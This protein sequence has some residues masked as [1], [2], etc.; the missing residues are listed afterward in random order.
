MYLDV[1]TGVSVG[2]KPDDPLGETANRRQLSVYEGWLAS[3]EPTVPPDAT[4]PPGTSLAGTLRV[5][6]EGRL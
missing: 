5:L 1:Y 6:A 4:G 3:L 2:R